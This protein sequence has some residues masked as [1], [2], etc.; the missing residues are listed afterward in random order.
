LVIFREPRFPPSLR[1]DDEKTLRSL[2]LGRGLDQHTHDIALLHD[3]EFRAVDFDFGARP[4]AEQHPVTGLEVDRDNFA[5]LI[6]PAWAD[7]DDLALVSPSSSDRSFDLSHT[8]TR[9]QRVGCAEE[10]RP[11]C[12]AASAREANVCAHHRK[13]AAFRL[14]SVSAQNFATA[15]SAFSLPG[16]IAQP[17]FSMDVP[18][19]QA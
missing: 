10:G 6:A 11:G 12:S 2:F 13:S 19:S 7:R 16:I 4:F 5:G 14:P 8:L 3:E 18:R 9:P 15:E 1:D 17:P